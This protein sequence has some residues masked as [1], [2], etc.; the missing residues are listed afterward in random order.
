VRTLTNL[1]KEGHE[2][3][4]MSCHKCTRTGSYRLASLIVRHGADK[5][6]PD[7]LVELSRDCPQRTPHGLELCGATFTPSE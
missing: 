5:G 2:R 4:Y 1:V 7:L 3:V 6:L